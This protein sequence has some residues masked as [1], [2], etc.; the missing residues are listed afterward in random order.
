VVIFSKGDDNSEDLDEDQNDPPN[1]IK[2]L[3]A[4]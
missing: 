2:E 3:L 4:R 1:K